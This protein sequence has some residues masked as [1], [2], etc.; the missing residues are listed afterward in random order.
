VLFVIGSPIGHLGDI[1]FRAIEKL[2][3]ADLVACEDT[4]HSAILLTHYQIRKPLISI[5]EHNEAQRT[6]ELLPK[7]L[8]GAKVALLTDAGMP[9]VSDPGLR[10]IR[11]C[12]QS[13]VPITVVPGPS[14]V[15]TALVGSSLP[16]EPFYF[17]GFLPSKSG[18][19][20]RELETALERACTSV[21][22]ESPHRLTRSLEI[23][24]A[25]APDRLVCVAREMTKKFE[26]FYQ[27]TARDVFEHYQSATIRGEITLLIGPAPKR[28]RA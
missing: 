4:R 21:Y 2:R 20:R 26:E 18:Q 19:R 15:L 23:L 25:S 10:L 9:G 6:A 12:R 24:S 22:F 17:V 7:L 5:H 3:E 11:A 16:T 8:G 28:F 14:A 13:G 27:G 1:T